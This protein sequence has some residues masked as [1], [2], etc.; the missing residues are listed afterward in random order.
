MDIR[1]MLDI[2]VYVLELLL[3]Q[4]P[5]VGANYCKIAV[6]P[7]YF[8]RDIVLVYIRFMFDEHSV[9]YNFTFSSLWTFTSCRSC[10]CGN[11]WTVWTLTVMMIV[12]DFW[13][14]V[15]NRFPLDIVLHW[16]F[17]FMFL[18]ISYTGNP[19]R[20][21][22]FCRDIV[23]FYVCF[24]LMNVRFTIASSLFYVG[25]SLH[26]F[27][28]KEEH[29]FY[30]VEQCE[31]SHFFSFTAFLILSTCDYKVSIYMRLQSYNMHNW[32]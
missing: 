25:H 21:C 30:S 13:S 18:I 2:L 1:F 24:Q 20:P 3:H 6:W 22:Y 29:L 12:I 11:V 15:Y 14:F 8:L 16:I 19:A 32:I 5:G 17:R 31:S 4:D 26:N 7:C 23:L 10:M 9:D 27:F 28:C